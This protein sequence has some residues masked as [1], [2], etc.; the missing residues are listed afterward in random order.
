MV[1]HQN[2]EETEPQKYFI[3][4]FSNEEIEALEKTRFILGTICEELRRKD[5]NAIE[6]KGID[7]F[8]NIHNH[9]FVRHNIEIA[10][11]LIESLADFGVVE[12]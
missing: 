9:F 1:V 12:I 4:S 10:F 3:S 5:K 7:A 2:P 8:H 6:V 11:K